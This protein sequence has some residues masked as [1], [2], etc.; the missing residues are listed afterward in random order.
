MRHST[1]L[2]EFTDISQ[3]LEYLV[4]HSSQMIFVTGEDL[5]IQQG[6][7]EAFLGQQSAHANVAFLTARRGKNS[8]FYRQQLAEQLDLD[9]PRNKQTLAQVF[10]TRADKTEP[11]LIA[12]TSAENVPEDVLRELWDLVLQ[13]RFTRNGEQINIL[14][15]GDQIWAEEVK[16]WLPTNNNDKP[17][18]LTTQTLEYDEETEVE[19]DLDEMIANRRKVF[20]ERMKSRALSSG[21]SVSILTHWWMK[22]LLVGVF[23]VS[24]ASLLIWQYFDVTK[25]ALNEFTQFIFQQEVVNDVEPSE[26]TPLSTGLTLEEALIL[27]QS[28][29]ELNQAG[30]PPEMEEAELAIV[31]NSNRRVAEN[32]NQAMDRLEALDA[33]KQIP[34]EHVPVIDTSVN[35]S[36]NS[37]S[38]SSNSVTIAAIT[39][40]QLIQLRDGNAGPSTE[41]VTTSSGV[42]TVQDNPVDAPTLATEPPADAQV[43]N[44]NDEQLLIDELPTDPESV[45]LQESIFEAIM[46]LES[47]DADD[48]V[49]IAVAQTTNQDFSVPAVTEVSTP[50]SDPGQAPVQAGES[51]ENQSALA[52]T[53][54]S[55]SSESVGPS[56]TAIN[57]APPVER[58]DA[59]QTAPQTINDA[60][61]YPVQDIVANAAETVADR[62]QLPTNLG[63]ASNASTASNVT[64]AETYQFHEQLLLELPNDSYVLQLSGITTES[65]L[66]EYLVDNRM[67]NSVWVYKTR[68]YGGDWFVVLF[69]QNFASLEAARSGVS[70]LSTE[71]QAVSPFAKSVSQIK[72]EI[73]SD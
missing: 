38:D 60:Q 61:D 48:D 51:D 41:S 70:L 10:A 46:M 32:F 56:E 54:S 15:F 17:V 1:L 49:N 2:T 50:L 27:E 44:I 26:S 57:E 47:M 62:G 23:L 6:F 34:E 20:K 28:T 55:S 64:T 8:Q 21:E 22:L 13:N 11:V 14:M 16:S 53:Q 37:A 12:M 71:L 25:T 73:L 3:R 31:D 18:L 69:N 7:V 43:A 52:P 42:S 68:R 33:Q 58:N 29:D 19:G 59:S 72:N 36:V 67:L 63:D 4:A 65:L 39:T 35:V 66:E 30:V 9:E 40:E 24:F 5:A 45:A